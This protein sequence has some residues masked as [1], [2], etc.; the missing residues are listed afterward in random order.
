MLV[1]GNTKKKSLQV[2]L[3]HSRNLLPVETLELPV[4]LQP[5][6]Q[7]LILVLIN[8][9]HPGNPLLQHPVRL[10]VTQ[11]CLGKMEGFYLKNVNGESIITFACFVEE[12]DI[13]LLIVRRNL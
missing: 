13:L 10:L 2:A 7:E 5:P 11:K 3:L 1:I 4:R 9:F 8:P 6:L 12:K